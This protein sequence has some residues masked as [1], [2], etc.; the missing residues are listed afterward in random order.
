MRVKKRLCSIVLCALLL[1]GCA[2]EQ[3]T[4]AVY[5]M[6]EKAEKVH[7]TVEVTLGTFTIK[8][9]TAVPANYMKM[10]S[11]TVDYEDAVLKER[12]HLAAGD[13]VKAGDVIAT[14]TFKTNDVELARLEL[15]YEKAVYSKETGA[16]SYYQSIASIKGNDRVS[17][18]QRLQM[19]YQL[20]SYLQSADQRCQQALEQLDAYKARYQ[21]AQIVAPCDGIVT[22]VTPFLKPGDEL[23]YGT[24]LVT[25]ADPSSIYLKL[26]NITMNQ[27]DGP[28]FYPMISVGS[29][30]KVT[31]GDYNR[32]CEVTS[33]PI[34][35]KLYQD[36]ETT[37]IPN[38][39]AYLTG[40]GL[41]SLPGTGTFAIEYTLLELENMMVLPL[42]AVHDYKDRYAPMEKVGSVSVQ[43]DPYVNLLVDGHVI[44]RYVV[45]GPSNGE[46]VCI[47]DGLT[48]GQLVIADFGRT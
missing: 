35:G 23:P 27:Y 20:A 43:K 48:P 30:A 46:E 36:S 40:D 12:T 38:G 6:P 41:E 7:R 19:E 24:E 21:E 47:L 25:L 28:V 39:T 11:V 13:H 10:Q 45:C 16:S 26:I 15:A 22:N 2:Q 31:K 4:S 32:T 42:H 9:K 18:L 44:K 8:K 5:Q 1:A 17:Y 37:G 14:F 29:T 33:A 3:Q 34:L